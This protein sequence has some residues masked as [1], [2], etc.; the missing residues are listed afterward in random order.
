[1]TKKTSFQVSSGQLQQMS[2]W[3]PHV[4]LTDLCFSAAPP[5]YQ[6]I[7]GAFKMIISWY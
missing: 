6:D 2:C 1:V 7:H 4:I 3:F 5:N